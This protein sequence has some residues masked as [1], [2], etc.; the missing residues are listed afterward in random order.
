VLVASLILL[1]AEKFLGFGVFDPAIGG[2]PVLFQRLFWFFGR[3]ALYIMILPAVGIVSELLDRHARG[4]I[5]G[6]RGIVYSII[7]IA[8]LGSLTSGSH[9]LVTDQSYIPALIS[10]LAGFLGTI[11]FF[12]ILL[13]WI[14][15][16]SRGAISYSA[17]MFYVLGFVALI[18]IGGLSGL[19]LSA[20]G[21]SVHLHSTYFV[22]AHF[23]YLLAGAALMAYL[24][25]LHFWWGE[26]SGRSF[27]ETLGKISAVLVFLGI[28]MS[29]LPQFILGFLG[30]P[31]RYSAYPVE[32]EGLQVL[33]SAGIPVLILGY[34]APMI[35]LAGSYWWG[36]STG[37]EPETSL[38]S[39]PG[40]A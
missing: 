7:A 27:P 39:H 24:G 4:R 18:M 37:R 5:V 20:T 16:L 21:V 6:Y 33:A 2:D 38:H 8:I 23:H 25:G 34:L 10:S 28:N 1:I 3:P 30:M 17:S 19:A 40:S 13:C 36:R 11:P 15:T 35:Y 29:F 32:F 12:F 14:L 9:L 26:L 31:R 22:L